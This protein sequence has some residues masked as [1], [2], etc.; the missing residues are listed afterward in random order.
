MWEWFQQASYVESR[1]TWQA[2]AARLGVAF[3]LGITSAAIRHFTIRGSTAGG[4][5]SDE[6]PLA[7]TLVLLSV[8]I[9]LVTIVIADNVARA[10]SLAG[11]LAIVRFRTVV[12][13]TRDTAFVIYSVVAGMAAGT[14]H[15]LAPVMCVPLV[16]VTAWVFRSRKRRGDRRD[17]MLVLRLALNRPPDDEG[18]QAIFARHLPSFRLSGLTTARGGAAFD[19]TY[20]V[21]FPTSDRM[22]AMVSELSR[23]DGVQ[24][25]E[26]KET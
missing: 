2:V 18:L 10:F 4:A 25:V 3:A 20:H 13:D 6:R 7:A 8:L 15:L 5:A 16:L 12:E 23:V 26:L 9:A 17:G 21:E 19:A 1:I 14:G 11:A 24:G 22:Y